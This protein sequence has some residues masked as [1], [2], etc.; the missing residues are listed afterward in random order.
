MGGERFISTEILTTESTPSI[1]REIAQKREQKGTTEILVPYIDRIRQ[2]AEKLGDRSAVVQL[3]QE[4]FLSVQHALMEERSKKLHANP[5]RV[6]KWFPVMAK[7]VVDMKKYEEKY[8]DQIDPVIGA[9]VYRFLGRFA[10]QKGQYSE[11]EKLYKKGLS[12]FDSLTKPEERYH[13]LELTGF[14]SHSQ[15]KQGKKEGL[16][17]A[18]QTLKDFDT[19]PEGLWLKEND[20]YTWAVWKS[21]I[22]IR[23]AQHYCQ[24]NDTQ[25]L[26]IMRDWIVDAE[27]ILQTPDGDKEPF[28]IRLDELNNVKELIK[29][30]PREQDMLDKY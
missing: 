28:E 25:K 21:G 29:S 26:E 2:Q 30:K 13:R 9:R 10:D 11:S 12:Y 1:L 4:K 15:I 7:T 19:S 24:K 8:H 3:Y 16:D 23:T 5:L 14:I 17:L 27:S 18:T 6:A 20:Y 22:E